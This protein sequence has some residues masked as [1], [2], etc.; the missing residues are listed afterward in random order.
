[1]SSESVVRH[2]PEL[3]QPAPEMVPAAAPV[4][5]PEIEDEVED[6]RLTVASPRQLIWWRFKKHRVAL[7]CGVLLAVFYLI[8]L[9]AEVV[10]PYD[11]GQIS[12]RFRYVN[13]TPITFFDPD[14]DFTFWP[15][16]NPLIASRDPVT[17]RISYVPD[18]AV[19]YPVQFFVRGSEYKLW[20]LFPSDIHLFG[21]GTEAPDQPLFLLGTDRL[22]RDVFTRV[23]YG[24]RLSLS[25]GL[26]GVSL[27]FLLGITLGGISG[28]YGG[29]IDLVVQRAIEFLRSMPQIPLWM[30]LAAAIPPKWPVEYTYFAITLILSLIGWTGLARVVRGRFLSLREE[31]F[32]LAARLCG[33]RQPRIIFRHMLPSFSSHIIASLTLAIPGTILG[34]TALSFLGLGLREPAISWGVLLQDA[35]NVQAVAL[36]PWLMLPAVPLIITIMAFNFFGDGLRDAADPY[37]K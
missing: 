34:E 21:L 24:A 30:A 35:Q 11:P 13:P 14:G 6:E 36:S 5:A 29:W 7:A 9:F 12:A 31:D 8:A 22:G 26:V 27:S 1:M 10:A 32:V 23:I 37:G 33:A 3:A 17:L 4:G 18:T 20:G 15:G 2:Q 16:V 28:Y 25:I 19:W